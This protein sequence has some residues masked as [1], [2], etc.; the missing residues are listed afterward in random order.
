MSDAGSIVVAGTRLPYTVIRS[1]RRQRTLGLAFDRDGALRVLVPLRT[2]DAAVVALLGQHAGWI[3][4][5]V[6]RF[7]AAPP[8]MAE[9][10]ATTWVEGYERVL[11]VTTS[12]RRTGRV[13]ITDGA[14]LVELSAGAVANVPTV[15]AAL[16]GWYVRRAREVLSE[17]LQRYAKA[18]GVTPG[19]ISIR[20]QRTRWGSCSP[21]GRLSFNLRLAMLPPALVEYVVV[22][23]LAHMTHPNHSERFWAHVARYCP[24]VQEQRRELRAWER[25]LPRLER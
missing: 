10:P 11:H 9:L 24:R 2:P 17:P 4:R 14:M 12:H 3:E 25:K 7:Q 19:A 18:M 8:R 15:S 1:A 16:L 23:E 20:N 21:T 22:H 6:Q 5:Q 13:S